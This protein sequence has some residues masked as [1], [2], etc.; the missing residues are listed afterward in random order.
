M[1]EVEK[2]YWKMF[3][4]VDK[5]VATVALFAT[6]QWFMPISHGCTPFY[7]AKHNISRYT[8]CIFPEMNAFFPET[9]EV[10]CSAFGNTNVHISQTWWMELLKLIWVLTLLI[11]FLLKILWSKPRIGSPSHLSWTQRKC[12]WT[13][14]SEPWRWHLA[15]V[16]SKKQFSWK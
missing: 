9:T 12:C 15:M 16:P 1:K 7:E 14:R 3:H 13:S 10:I 4:A 5:Q 6:N 8:A 2:N 11:T